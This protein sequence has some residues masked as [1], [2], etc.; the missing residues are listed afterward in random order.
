MSS[1]VINMQTQ[2]FGC[3]GRGRANILFTWHSNEKALDY[4]WPAWFGTWNHFSCTQTVTSVG[5]VHM[6][7]ASK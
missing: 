5:L 1:Q 7:S 2:W 4:C 6:Q 3:S